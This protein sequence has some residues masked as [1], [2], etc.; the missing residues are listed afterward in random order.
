[1]A[2]VSTSSTWTEKG[3]SE[4]SGIHRPAPGPAERRLMP[5]YTSPNP[6]K[7]VGAWIRDQLCLLEESFSQRQSALFSFAL[8]LCETF[9]L[10]LVILLSYKFRH[11]ATL[12]P[13]YHDPNRFPPV[14]G[15]SRT[16]QREALFLP[17]PPPVLL[18]LSV[19]PGA[20]RPAAL[21]LA[22]LPGEE[23]LHH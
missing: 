4:S 23:R 2:G 10:A 8:F 21:A 22:P 11:C 19:T 12:L 6:E 7:E 5:P 3:Q 15:F 20:L 9:L 13:P 1:M 14:R 18:H 16:S 17:P